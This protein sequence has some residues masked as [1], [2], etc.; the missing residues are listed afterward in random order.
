MKYIKGYGNLSFGSVKGLTDKFYG[1]IK[2]RKR[3]SFVIDSYLQ[4]FKEKQSSKQDM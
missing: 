1:F 2:W 4:Q 3:S